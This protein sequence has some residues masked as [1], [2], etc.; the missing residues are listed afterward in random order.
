M[1]KAFPAPDGLPTEMRAMLNQLEENERRR[2]KV[3]YV[4]APPP[5]H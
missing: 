3:H 2:G 4:K 5:S 1:A